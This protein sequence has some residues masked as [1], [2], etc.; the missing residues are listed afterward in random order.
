MRK[1]KADVLVS[2]GGTV[3]LFQPVTRAARAWVEEHVQLAGW[4]WLGP[5]FAVEHRYA[6][7]LAAGMSGDGLVVR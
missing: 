6:Q 4:Q 2:G 7:D 3:Y 5:A 1:A